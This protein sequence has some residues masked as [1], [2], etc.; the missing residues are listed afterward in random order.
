MN[1]VIEPVTSE[2]LDGVLPLIRM[3]QE[4]YKVKDVSET[5]NIEFFSQFGPENPNG[6][7]FTYRL[8]EIVA[9]FAT[10]YF[11]F[12]ST[13][14]GKVAILNDLFTLPEL[15]GKG[16]GR[17]LIE[18]CRS[19]AAEN[20]AVRLQWVTAPDNDTAQKLYNSMNTG[21]STWRLYVYDT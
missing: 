15:R 6:C 11:S 17:Q 21:K 7:Q 3:Y 8:N 13:I 14:P 19:Y 12:S 20:G 4:F 5:K 16:I 2:N 1:S 18:H 10:V 9:G